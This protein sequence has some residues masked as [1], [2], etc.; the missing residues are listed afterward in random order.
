VE[1]SYEVDSS[2]FFQQVMKDI[3]DSQ[4]R[5]FSGS[6]TAAIASEARASADEWSRTSHSFLGEQVASASTSTLDMIEAPKAC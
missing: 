1:A 5:S 3:R 4:W 6:L 2:A